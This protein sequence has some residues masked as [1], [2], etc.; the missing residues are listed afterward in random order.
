MRGDFEGEAIHQLF[1]AIDQFVHDKPFWLFEVD[2]SELGHSSPSAR[3]AGAQRMGK[4]PD[5]AMALYGGGLAQRAVSGLFLKLI[6][7]FTGSH[8]NSSK[9]LKDHATARAWLLAEQE[10]RLSRGR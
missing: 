7:L 8:D 1:D 4:T 10:R 5:Y 2:I 9:Y 6:D 3:K